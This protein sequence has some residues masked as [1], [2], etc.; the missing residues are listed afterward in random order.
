MKMKKTLLSLSIAATSFGFAACMNQNNSSSQVIDAAHNSRNA[1]TWQGTYSG[2]TPC[3]DCEGIKTSLT[4]Q[5]NTYVLETTY[6]GKS[7]KVY[8][9]EGNF[10][11]N[12]K[13]SI[14]TLDGEKGGFKLQ[15]RVGENQLI[16]LDNEGNKIEG[17]FAE[18]YILTK[19]IK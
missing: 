15:Y 17:Q 18:M 12:E 10:V 2:T 7:D 3:A 13:G 1:L 8:K 16:Q 14:I 4:L 6:L 9:E 5:E 19:V 11:W